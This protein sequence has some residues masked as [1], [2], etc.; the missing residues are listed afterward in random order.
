MSATTVA[1]MD[2]QQ[3]NGSL[4]TFSV[5]DTRACHTVELVQDVICESDNE[6]F[7][8]DLT[9]VSGMQPITINPT[10]EVVI[11]DSAEPEC[12]SSSCNMYM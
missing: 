8:S 2:Y 10:T 4:L 6:Y 12:K 3:R 9:Y 5:G 7:F 1:G 11:D